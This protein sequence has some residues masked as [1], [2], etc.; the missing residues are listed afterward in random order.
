[1]RGSQRA[2]ALLGSSSSRWAP[3]SGSKLLRYLPR[4]SLVLHLS[5]PLSG[6][7]LR[8]T[9]LLL[10]LHKK[11]EPKRRSSPGQTQA[12][13][14]GWETPQHHAD[15]VSG[16]GA[17]QS[18]AQHGSS[19]CPSPAVSQS[20]LPLPCPAAI[21]PPCPPRSIYFLSPC[22]QHQQLPGSTSSSWE[23]AISLRLV[24]RFLKAQPQIQHFK[25]RSRIT[26]R[27]NFHNCC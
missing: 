24:P 20:L 16:K 26:P 18:Q 27:C 9:R 6:P 21:I 2:G 8:S 4:L 22:A 5:T 14:E 19:P 15:T 25:N 17:P 13:T 10:C 23:K 3:D 12:L 7:L 11:E 1:M